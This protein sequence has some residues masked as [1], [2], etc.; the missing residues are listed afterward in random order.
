MDGKGCSDT[1]PA[2][3][4][5]QDLHLP[6][7]QRR[8]E[9]ACLQSPGVQ[10][11]PQNCD[12]PTLEAFTHLCPT[13]ITR[14][15]QSYHHTTVCPPSGQ[16]HMQDTC[17]PGRPSLLLPPQ[18][19]QTI[20][21]AAQRSHPSEKKAGVVYWIPWGTCGR[22][23][24]GHTSWTLNQQL[25]EHKR[26]LTSGNL[27]QSAIY[28]RACHGRD[29]CDRLEGGTGHGQSSTPHTAMH[30][31][32][33]AHL[34][35]TPSLILLNPLSHCSPPFTTQLDSELQT[36]HNCTFNYHPYFAAPAII[37]LP[38]LPFPHVQ[39]VLALYTDHHHWWRPLD[40]GRCVWSIDKIQLS[41]SSLASV[42]PKILPC[43]KVSQNSDCT[44]I[45]I[46][47][48]NYNWKYSTWNSHLACRYHR[49]VTVE[50]A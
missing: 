41:N 6:A 4:S 17:P 47:T 5:R 48:H 16:V 33:V 2:N 14:N 46:P 9:G 30:I 1:D 37:L 10:R 45:Y 29:A 23:Y 11:L 3:Q 20:P 50:N 35:I 42:V 22:A 18:D 8:R 7:W 31:G 19:T 36:S 27:A 26:A 39:K 15:A 38:P 28:S 24:I 34:R 49:S 13:S 25:K 40:W 21:G 44:Y 32:G 12:P 43:N